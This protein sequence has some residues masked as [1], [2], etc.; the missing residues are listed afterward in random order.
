MSA[1]YADGN[2]V[3]RHSDRSI[4]SEHESHWAAVQVLLA[5]PADDEEPDAYGRTGE[6]S[7]CGVC[8][9]T[10]VEYGETCVTCGGFGWVRA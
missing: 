2:T 8:G 9:A 3:R 4:V 5:L 10:G 7:D 1:H 6:Q